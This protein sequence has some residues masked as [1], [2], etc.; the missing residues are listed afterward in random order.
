MRWK[1][2]LNAF[3]ITSYRTV[4]ED[5]SPKTADFL[6]TVYRTDPMGHPY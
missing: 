2:A 1:L 6:H 5:H 3:A 4:R